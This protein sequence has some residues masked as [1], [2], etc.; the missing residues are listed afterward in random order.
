[1]VV[2]FCNMAGNKKRHQHTLFKQLL[3][4]SHCEGISI[5]QLPPSFDWIVLFLKRA[6]FVIQ[7]MNFYFPVKF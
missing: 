4:H 6:K 1:M 7:I 3:F 5:L 2:P